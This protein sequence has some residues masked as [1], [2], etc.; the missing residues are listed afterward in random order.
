MKHG[1]IE[2]A[3]KRGL[4]RGYGNL[5]KWGSKVTARHPKPKRS[6][7]KSTKKVNLKLTCEQCNK[8]IIKIGKRAKK[9]ELKEK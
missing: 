2:R 7:A 5:G 6:G 8:S 1:S 9:I 3:R 4:G